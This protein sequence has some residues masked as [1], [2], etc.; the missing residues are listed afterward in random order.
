MSESICLEAKPSTS[1]LSFGCI[2]V[3]FSISGDAHL[4]IF[5]FINLFKP[6]NYQMGEEL[7]TLNVLQRRK[8]QMENWGKSEANQVPGDWKVAEKIEFPISVQFWA[9]CSNSDMEEINRLLSLGIDINVAN[10]D[11][12]TSLHQIATTISSNFLSSE[13]Q[14][15]TFRIMKVGHHFMRRLHV[16][17]SK[18]QGMHT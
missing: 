17:I 6:C 15:L 18:L 13:A 1:V 2:P 14:M 10:V 4:G 9:A 11:G 7:C 8:F 12:L 5:I 3:D 16:A